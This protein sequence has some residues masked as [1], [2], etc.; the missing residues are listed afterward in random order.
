MTEFEE[1]LAQDVTG[2]KVLLTEQTQHIGTIEALL[3]FFVVCLLCW[4][5]YKF[6][7][8]FF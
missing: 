8:M 1:A 5:V 3:I 4:A 7:R 6:F 2:I